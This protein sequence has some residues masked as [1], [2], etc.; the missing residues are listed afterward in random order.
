MGDI[1]RMERVGGHPVIDFVNT[2]GG[3]PDDPNDEYMFEYSDLLTFAEGSGL[4]RSEALNRL[5]RAARRHRSEVDDV[6]AGALQ[7]RGHID[8]ILR[9]RVQGRSAPSRDLDALLEAYVVALSFAAVSET[10]GNYDWDWPDGSPSL[11]MPLWPI[12]SAAVEL[13]RYAP[14]DRLGRCDHCRWLFLDTSRSGSRRW[15]SMNGC[16]SILKMR[17]YRAARRG[18]PGS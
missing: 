15:C 4:L 11:D 14:L 6:L 2:L 17:R 13:L 5:R 10:G 1:A 16:G 7:L 18:L 9:A 3:L 12:S 8:R